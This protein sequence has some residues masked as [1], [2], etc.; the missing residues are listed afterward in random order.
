MQGGRAQADAVTSYATDT[1]VPRL[2]R[3]TGVADVGVSGGPV[4]QIQVLIDPGKL[5]NYNLTPARLTQAIAASALD[6][7]AGSLTQGGS[8]IGF[9]TRN[10][11]TTVRDVNNIIVDP[12]T[13][14]TVAD[15]ATV[16]DTAAAP[17]SYA[18]LNGQ[19][20]VLLNVRKSSGTNSVSVADNVRA[21]MESVRLPAGYSLSLAS[22]TTRTTRATV[23]DTFK[24]FLIGIG[25]VGIVVLLFLGR[26]NTVFAVVLAIPISISAAPLFYGLFGF[27]FNLIS[28]LAIIVAIGIV[29]DD[30]IVV[31]ENVQRYRDQGYGQVQSVLLGGSEVFS[32]G[33]GGQLLAAGG[34]GAAELYARHPGPVLP[35]VCH[36]PDRR[37]RPELAGIAAVSDRA[38]GLHPRPRSDWLAAVWTA[39]GPVSR[40]HQMGLCPPHPAQRLGHSGAGHLRCHSVRAIAANRPGH[41]CGHPALSADDRPAALP[42]D[43]AAGPAWKP[44]PPPCTASSTRA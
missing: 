36:R 27:T 17:T 15:V 31:A 30:S 16:R 24:E 29:V 12:Q 13:G 42:A 5:Q 41:L 44:S 40:D 23:N 10:T 4:R 32:G 2:Q 6:L 18:R 11:P 9:S 43:G 14:L 21:S 20:A 1:L 22:D 37:H 33:H 8:S 38:Y 19:P 39:A 7:P 28:L 35:A 25:A 34:T 3:V 26:L